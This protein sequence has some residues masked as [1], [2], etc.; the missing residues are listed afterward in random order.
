MKTPSFP[1]INY[2]YY[3][4]GSNK[5]ARAARG[6]KDRPLL[7]SRASGRRRHRGAPSR[8]ARHRRPRRARAATQTRPSSPPRCAPAAAPEAAP[9][10]CR[11]LPRR[12]SRRR[13][14][15]GRTRARWRAYRGCSPS[16]GRVMCCGRGR[17][18]TAAEAVAGKRREDAGR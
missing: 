11:L 4:Q 9:P 12:S 14:R 15:R 17:S 10:C 6:G 7:P 16:R 3:C 5:R 1:V 18:P 8:G 13:E 2:Y